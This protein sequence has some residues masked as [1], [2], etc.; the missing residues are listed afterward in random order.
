MKKTPRQIEREAAT[1]ARYLKSHGRGRLMLAEVKG[2]MWWTDSYIAL[3]VDEAMERLLAD[4]NLKPEPMYCNVGRTIVRNDNTPVDLEEFLGKW[5]AKRGMV[6]VKP[7][8]LGGST[9]MVPAERGGA[10]MELWSTD[11]EKVT[12]RPNSALVARVLA[13]GGDRFMVLDGTRSPLVRYDG[14]EPIG[15]TMALS[16]DPMALGIDLAS[17]QGEAA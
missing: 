12:H 1:L 3:R 7:L 13:G 2:R 11:G 10:L 14:D 4:Y 9:L 5:T 6:E 17:V 15:L 8:E 16:G